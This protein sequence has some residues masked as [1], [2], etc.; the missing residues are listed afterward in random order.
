MAIFNPDA[1]L[2]KPADY[3]RSSQGTKADTSVG[4]LFE[5][6]GTVIGQGISS[7]YRA[8]KESLR[9]QA[10]ED[11]DLVQNYIIGSGRTP[12]TGGLTQDANLPKEI[13]DQAKKQTLLKDAIMSGKVSHTTYSM[14]LDASARQLRAKYPGFREEIDNIYQDMTGSIP[15]NKVIADLFSKAE[16]KGDKEETEYRHQLHKAQENGTPEFVMAQNNGIKLSL[17]DLTRYNTNAMARN[18][19][20]DRQSK[21]L[22]VDKA[23]SEAGFRQADTLARTVLFGGLDSSTSAMMNVSNVDVDQVNKTLTR[24]TNDTA[25][26]KAP[27]AA[28]TTQLVEQVNKA[29]ISLDKNFNDEM[30][31]VRYDRDNKPYRLS[32]IL[33]AEQRKAYQ[34]EF[35]ERVSAWA[36]PLI[37]GDRSMFS[38]QMIWKKAAEDQGANSVYHQMDWLPKMKA[39]EGALGQTLTNTLM[40]RDEVALHH[41][42]KLTVASMLGDTFYKNSNVSDVLKGLDQQIA[43]GLLDPTEAKKARQEYINKITKIIQD[44]KVDAKTANDVAFKV[45][46][47]EQS[48]NWLN[49]VPNWKDKQTLYMKFTDPR[50][51]EA[52]MKFGDAPTKENYKQWV[53]ANGSSML[54]QFADTAA[55]NF[56]RGGSQHTIEFDPKTI[57]FRQASRDRTEPLGMTEEPAQI[58]QANNRNNYINTINPVV[59]SWAGVMKKVGYSDEA[60]AKN[61]VAI[62]KSKGVDISSGPVKSEVNKGTNRIP[63]TTFGLPQDVDEPKQPSK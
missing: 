50:I 59:A 34:S 46:G 27:S 1:P 24:I 17:A 39:I 4:S 25:N 55:S 23:K 16:N 49:S 8:K 20:V 7:L 51:S 35:K 48:T 37:K 41:I 42:G 60:I 2:D 14:M 32:E 29:V 56:V 52:I 6:V 53:G 18:A 58:S 5:G 10:A 38:L 21:L 44:P 61:V 36:D 40:S 30:N 33:N 31:K 19:E 43:N 28:D 26:N 57:S 12:K 62:F 11:I 9:E 47:G 22:S 45:F 15:A 3:T 63:T 54:N 13:Q